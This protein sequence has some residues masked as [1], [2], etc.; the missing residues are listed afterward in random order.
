VTNY[1][2]TEAGAAIFGPHPKGLPRPPLSLGHPLQ[3]IGFRLIDANGKP[4]REG[5]L[6]VKTPAM[7]PGYIN[8]PDATAKLFTRDGWLSTGD[9]IRQ[10]ND[11]F[12]YFVR[13]ADDMFVCGG[14]NIYPA[15][16]EEIL[17]NHPDVQ[18]AC[19]VPVPDELK[20]A[21][22]IAFVTLRR[23]S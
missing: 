4:A 16:V 22:P 6:E 15:A 23:A 2:T 10:D 9:V 17:E 18:Q 13:R 8:R 20:G 3:T 21:K 14:E 12:C 1:G 19:V 11:G 5:I 7:T